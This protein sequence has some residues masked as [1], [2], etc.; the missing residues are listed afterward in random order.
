MNL[1]A[2]GLAIAQTGRG[3]LSRGV[4]EGCRA[5]C[6]ANFAA[7]IEVVEEA[8]AGEPLSREAV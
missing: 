1:A 2:V 3:E 7:A 8:G 5:S 6:E 4:R